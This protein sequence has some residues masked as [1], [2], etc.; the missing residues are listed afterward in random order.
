[1]A[2][3]ANGRRGSDS[4]ASG[5]VAVAAVLL[6]I[7]GVLNLLRAVMA[8]AGDPVFA[9]V[10]A[11]AFR[12]TLTGW[13]WIDLVLGVLAILVGLA[14]FRL[15]LWARIAGAAIACLLIIANFLSIPYYPLWSIVVIGACLVVIWGLCTVRHTPA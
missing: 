9:P 13:G 4:A 15:A 1:M 11:Y 7:S 14:L 2:Q 12:F 10:P 3:A 5:V 6:L 8:L